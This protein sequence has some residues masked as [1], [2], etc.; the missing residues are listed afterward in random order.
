MYN[1]L[2]ECEEV[3]IHYSVLSYDSIEIIVL[4]V[5]DEPLKTEDNYQLFFPSETKKRIEISVQGYFSKK[6]KKIDGYGCDD[7]YLFKISEILKVDDVTTD[8]S[9]SINNK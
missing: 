3:N 7:A 5:F 6:P 2:Q 4:P 9:Y 1:K 8:F